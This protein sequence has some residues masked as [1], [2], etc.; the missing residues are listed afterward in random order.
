MMS[1]L[2]MISALG[3]LN[4]LILT[5]ARIYAAA[6]ADFAVFASLARWHERWGTPV[7]AIL[8][9]MVLAL[10]LVLLVGSAAGRSLLDAALALVGFGPQSW[11]GHGGFDT[12]LKCTA[13]VFWV[14]F[15]LT[16][17][18]LFVLRAKEPGV[19]R[20]FSVPL[21]PVLPAVFCATCAYML[22]SATNYAG[23]LAW[24]GLAPPL[25][26]LGVFLLFGRRLLPDQ[27]DAPSGR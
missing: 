13:P 3:A 16:G 1:V 12:L 6:G 7:R 15:L 10:A 21:Y 5:G 23:K 2:V 24:I 22:Y 20:P 14:F 9:Q 17:L 26:G 18:A 8:A 4:G 19:E 27:T 25:S 11:D